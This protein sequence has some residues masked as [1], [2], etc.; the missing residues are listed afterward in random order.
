MEQAEASRRRGAPVRR[1][2]DARCRIALASTGSRTER[3]GRALPAAARPRGRL[4]RD[5]RLRG[6]GGGRGAPRGVRTAG[7]CEPAAG[8]ARR[9]G[10]ARRWLRSRYA[11]P[12]LRDEL[13]DRGVMVET[14]E[15]ATSWSNL[16]EPLRGGRGRAAH[17]ARRA[18]HAAA[19]DVPRVAPVSLGRVALLHLPGPS[20][21]RRAGPVARGQDGRVGGD[22]RRAAAR[23]RTTTRSA[24]TTRRG[25]GPRWGSWGSS[26]CRRPRSAST[27]PGS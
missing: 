26:C 18:R 10:R 2:R 1:A 6:R 9:A 16:D 25:C 17:A 23:S 21:G 22:R 5:P 4:P 13:L 15:T 19:R 14:L 27:P 7:C 3:L 24:A 20:G 8:C 12:Y 11:G